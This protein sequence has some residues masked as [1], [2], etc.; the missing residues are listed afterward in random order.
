MLSRMPER[1]LPIAY[2]EFRVPDPMVV[3][4]LFR[5]LPPL[6]EALHLCDIYYEHAKY[7]WVFSCRRLTDD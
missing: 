6:S 2:P 7:T 5:S 1:M 4:Q 3:S